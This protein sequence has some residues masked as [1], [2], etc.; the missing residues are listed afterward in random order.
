MRELIADLRFAARLL[1]KNP[2]TT[3]L[4]VIALGFGIGLSTAIFNAFSAILLRPL[5]HIRDEHRLV[6]LNSLDLRRP[7]GF[8]ELSLPDFLDL[9]A[10]SKTLAGLTTATSKTVIF[11]GTGTPERVLGA[12]ISA[13]GFA[14]LGV[15][16][17]R[18]RVFTPADA[19]P[20]APPT[21][22][23]SYA[24]WQRRFGGRDDVIG[25][26]EVMNGTPTTIIGVLPRGFGFPDNHEMWT[27]MVYKNDPNA[28]ASHHLGGWAR[29]RDG[30]TLDEAR[31]EIA[32]IGARLALEHKATNE[33]K[34]FALR[35]VREE[36]TEDTALLMRLMLGAALFVLLIACANVANLL[37]AKAAGR[38]HEIAIRFS[39]GATRT[40]IVR[41]LLTE[42]LL[43]GLLG[44]AAGLLV[45]VWANGLLLSVVPE[46]EI[47][48]WMTFDFDWRVFAFAAGA[49]V[50]SALLFG[51]F[52]ALQA[53][54]STALEMKEGGRG[55]A[56]SRR[57]RT[58]RQGLVV[59]QVA[60]SAV[61]LIGA[62]LFV[63]SFL[64]LQST[65]SG[66]D[67]QGLLTFRV[68][69]PPTQF[70]DRDEVR[71]FFD[72]LTPR[73]AEVPGVTAVAATAMLPSSG[74][75]SNSFLLEGQ[76]LPRNVAESSQTTARLVS[77]NY[78]AT[79]RIPVLRGRAFAATDTRESPRVAVVDQQFV[80][81][82]CNGQD[83]IGRRVRFG[84]RP[85]DDAPWMT[86]VGVVGNV[87]QQLDRPY[88]RGS[89]YQ[90]V[91]QNDANFLSY[92]VRAAGDPATYGPALQKA[93][94]TVRP[95]IP[96]YNVMTQA[97][98]EA[99][100][101]WERKF[102]GQV[103]S[104]FGLGAL[105]LSA[106]G[107]YGV[108]AYSV[109]QRTAEIGV[110]MALGASPGDVLRLVSRQG[111]ILVGAGLVLG[112]AAA[113]GLTRFMAALLYGIS[114]SDP[115]TYFVLTLV[116]AAVGLLACWLP[117]RRATQVDPILAL[118]AE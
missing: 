69:L 16:P 118:R 39:V 75:N 59:A 87:P 44:G 72:Q 4:A 64:K 117:A 32:A 31:A 86:I 96:I 50:A 83:P 92:V 49:A 77:A 66:Y 46:V 48:F 13:E 57:S 78:F 107:V 91:E 93:V 42:S 52:P 14:M 112:I 80:D 74:N 55:T 26:T 22:I 3:L 45:G 114:P 41:Q 95:D 9:R 79:M 54:R 36:A 71:R 89:V 99:L 2:S 85:E 63:R 90:L 109:A 11:A 62:G 24:L 21:A 34:G 110:R 103:F 20:T 56:G 51:L 113:L 33:G 30:V 98:V 47:P 116:L 38:A 37:L 19:E 53:A 28:R 81:K 102:F 65:P 23:L 1:A 6:Y 29:L 61:L 43:L 70:K 105:F 12:D 40:R 18:G 73:L 15:Q 111:F 5:P 8:Y 7:D 108:M 17:V 27:P 35:L 25:R 76:A 10:Q 68:G 58:L 84:Y 97:R 101:Y 67:A 94:L 100:A 60:L 106:L 88:E 115:P 104:A 82:W